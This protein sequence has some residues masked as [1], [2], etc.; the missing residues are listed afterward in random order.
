MIPVISGSSETQ[1]EKVFFEKVYQQYKRL[2]FSTA[3]KYATSRTEAEDILQ[4]AL[5]KL[6]KRIPKL[7]S[8]PSCALPTYLVFTVRSVAI[9]YRRHQSYI[10]KHIEPITPEEEKIYINTKEL[11]QDILEKKEMQQKF[12]AIWNQVPSEDANLLYRKYI[13]GQSDESLAAIFNCQ[14][15]SIRMKLTRAKRKVIILMKGGPTHD[16]T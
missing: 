8:L 13:L 12:A 7:M 2:L 14:K 16:E 5:E 4:D 9:N 3:I 11:P 10:E 6:L 15:D 1:N